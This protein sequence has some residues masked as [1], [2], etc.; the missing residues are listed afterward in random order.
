MCVVS[1]VQARDSSAEM[2]TSNITAM[3]H[4]HF[5]RTGVDMDKD[6]VQHKIVDMKMVQGPVRQ[7]VDDEENWKIVLKFGE[8]LLF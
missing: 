8:G 2:S 1:N 4:V 5:E 6:W 3:I 7:L